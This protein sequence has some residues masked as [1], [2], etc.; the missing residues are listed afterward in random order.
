M[1]NAFVD[2]TMAD[3]MRSEI[4]VWFVLFRDA[5]DGVACTAQEDIAR[6]AGCNRRNVHRALRR[7]E[8]R[9]LIKVQTGGGKSCPSLAIRPRLPPRLES[10]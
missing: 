9:G 10:T 4:A 5:R 8:E 1:L 3:L 6:R 7:L 2:G